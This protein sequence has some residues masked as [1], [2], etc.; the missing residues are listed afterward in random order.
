MTLLQI[1]QSEDRGKMS[2]LSAQGSGEKK[3]S[4]LSPLPAQEQDSGG[5]VLEFTGLDLREKAGSG[6]FVECENISTRN[7]PCLSPRLGRTYRD[8]REYQNIDDIFRF[9]G[10]TVYRK[11]G[12][13]FFG[14]AVYEVEDS[15][16]QFA[17]VNTKLTVWPDGVCVDIE[18]GDMT[19]LALD[20]TVTNAAISDNKTITGVFPG[21]DIVKTNPLSSYSD[22]EL[23]IPYYDDEDAARAADESEQRFYTVSRNTGTVEYYEDLIGRWIVPDAENAIRYG[24]LMSHRLEF[25][26]K[27]TMGY[28]GRITSIS[29]FFEGNYHYFEITAELYLGRPSS[30]TD[31]KEGDV[32]FVGGLLAADGEEADEMAMRVWGVTPTSVTF[33]ANAL[34]G[35]HLN[36]GKT[37]RIRRKVPQLDFVCASSNR[38]WGVSNAV[39][40]TVMDDDGNPVTF[41]GRAVF[42]SKLGDP[43]NWYYYQGV[44]MDSWTAAVASEGDFTGICAWSDDILCFKEREMFR[45][46]GSVPSAF[47]LYSF[48]VPGIERGSGGSIA[49][50]DEVVYYK[51]ERGIYRYS[52][53]TP[54]RVSERMMDALDGIG[55][56][57][58]DGRNYFLSVPSG[59]YVYDTW[60]NAWTRHDGTSDGVFASDSGVAL[61]L[62]TAVKKV[63][64]QTVRYKALA[65]MD[66]G[67]ADGMS[68][69][70]TM[71]P[72][73]GT[74]QDGYYST[75]LNMGYKYYKYV[76]LRGEL[77]LHDAGAAQPS[78][79]VQ[80][81]MG[82][83][84]WE[85]IGTQSGAGHFLLRMPVH[86]YREDRIQLRLSGVG[87]CVLRDIRYVYST[88]SEWVQ[89]DKGVM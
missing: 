40:N 71:H 44:S 41:N 2:P 16:K 17:V 80:A 56:A 51:N 31:I 54:T 22:V 34:L 20:I 15:H 79:T 68:W 50:I 8:E 70:V 60:H 10:K 33:P 52:G 18:T 58:T 28:Y 85:T 27:N 3:E 73:Y 32:V 78:V 49:I 9:D 89:S 81:K 19:P 46:T 7:Y 67:T 11:G 65:R 57:G 14:D 21:S 77:I 86:K 74:T 72:D 84:G 35:Y 43:S 55:N 25:P 62:F 75:S 12:R 88:G 23:V 45:I 13:L 69:R 87:D 61:I 38:L 39:E 64:G 82:G 37:V 29:R 26:D 53:G 5:Q 76:F 63:D 66:G 48:S 6:A 59:L 47:T 30:H 1:I 36:D 4:S 83:Y 42:C 24:Y